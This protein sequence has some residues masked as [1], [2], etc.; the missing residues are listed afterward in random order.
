MSDELIDPAA[1]RAYRLLDAEKKV[2]DA[3]ARL[4]PLARSRVMEAISVLYGFDDLAE[5]IRV[6]RAA[7][8]EEVARRRRRR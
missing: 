1:A 4:H 7:E 5:E 3:L 2:I 8:A 6:A